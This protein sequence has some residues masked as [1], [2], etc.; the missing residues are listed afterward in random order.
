MSKKI[1]Y[2][3]RVISYGE[4]IFLWSRSL[5]PTSFLVAARA[6]TPTRAR[7][8]AKPSDVRRAR[9]R[10]NANAARNVIATCKACAY[11]YVYLT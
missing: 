3:H 7:A 4:T 2:F 6:N 1:F 11:T 10:T 8:Q 9:S 5:P